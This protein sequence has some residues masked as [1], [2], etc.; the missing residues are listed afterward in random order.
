[1]TERRPLNEIPQTLETLVSYV[2]AGFYPVECQIIMELMGCYR[3]ITEED[4]LR[5]LQLERKQFRASI[6][7]L[8]KDRLIHVGSLNLKDQAGKSTKL[9][10]YYVNYAVFINVVKYKLLQMRKKV[11]TM[12]RGS[13]SMATY[14]CPSCLKMYNELDVGELFDPSS[15]T[16]RCSCCLVEVEETPTKAETSKNMLKVFNNQFSPF[17]ELL[18]I[19]DKMELSKVLLEQAPVI[20]TTLP[21]TGKMSICREEV[22]ARVVTKEIVNV[23]NIPKRALELP[24][25]IKNNA[26]GTAM[27]E[28]MDIL[29]EKEIK[30]TSQPSPVEGVNIFTSQEIPSV[31]V[32]LDIG[33]KSLHRPEEASEEFISDDDDDEFTVTFAGRKV[34]FVEITNEMVA[35]MTEAEKEEYIKVGREM[36]EYYE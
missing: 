14:H 6:C 30:K 22:K 24:P 20:D 26:I 28:P 17:F 29:Q 19:L 13:T 11:E 7:T 15:N 12:E 27:E 9:T 4:M 16:L 1:M 31:N 21:S 36:H 5:L 3:H 32:I 18:Q 10:Y 23:Q 25:W 2:T 35:R 33:E 8:K 34:P